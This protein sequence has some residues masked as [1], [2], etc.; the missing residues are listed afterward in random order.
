MGTIKR[1]S[2]MEILDSRGNPTVQ[3]R[4]DLDGGCIGL[5]A[6]PSGASTGKYEAV[7][8]RDGEVSRFEGMGV[9]KAIANVNDKIGPA[10]TGM[11]AL[12]QVAIDQKMIELDGTANKSNL[13]ANDILGVSL[14]VARAA[15]DYL[16]I[17]LYRYFGGVTPHALPVPMM[18]I[19]NG[20]K[21][22][23]DQLS[24]LSPKNRSLIIISPLVSL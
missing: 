15:T 10:L 2:A 9:L 20:G 14:A 7:E 8:L 1:I 16:M 17:P 3:V 12:D 21:H 4:V 5:A 23:A 13:G 24:W 18:N 22:A 6:V 19:L 11:S